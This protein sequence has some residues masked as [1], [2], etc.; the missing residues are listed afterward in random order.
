MEVASQTY[1]GKPAAELSLPE[2]GLRPGLPQAPSLNN[3]FPTQ[4]EHLK[5]QQVVLGLMK[6]DEFIS[7][8]EYKQA[9]ANPV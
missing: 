7:D 6:K 1:F 9:Q 3:P 8:A 5:R 4:T 2:C